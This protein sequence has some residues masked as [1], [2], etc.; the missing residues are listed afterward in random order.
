MMVQ[1]PHWV[2]QPGGPAPGREVPR[3]SSFTGQQ[4]LHTIDRSGPMSLL[5]YLKHLGES[6]GLSSVLS[7]YF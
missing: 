7:T 1:V 2:P 3:T 5:L 6:S 4:G